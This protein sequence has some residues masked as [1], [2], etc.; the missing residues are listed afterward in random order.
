MPMNSG[1]IPSSR[2]LLPAV[3]EYLERDRLILVPPKLSFL[4]RIL[5]FC[6]LKIYKG[7]R[8]LENNS[9]KVN[10]VKEWKN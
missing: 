2:M 9:E 6:S 8:E 5:G 1:K 10:R 4:I 7:Q 3:M